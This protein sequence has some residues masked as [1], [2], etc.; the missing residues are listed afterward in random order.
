[1]T[2]EPR[3][4][5]VQVEE[6]ARA[7]ESKSFDT[8]RKISNTKHTHGALMGTGAAGGSCQNL[9]FVLRRESERAFQFV[10]NFAYP[11]VLGSAI[12]DHHYTHTG[13]CPEEVA[14]AK[15]QEGSPAEIGYAGGEWGTPRGLCCFHT[16]TQP[17][18]KVHAPLLAAAPQ[19]SVSM[20]V[21]A[22]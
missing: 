19:H 1:M 15:D 12:N 16:M 11:S 21:S 10:L 5:P 3:P 13:G 4:V 7:M 22:H 6:A 18:R 2:S 8:T 17:M 20:S 14:A 9:H